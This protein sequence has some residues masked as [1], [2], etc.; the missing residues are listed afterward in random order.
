MTLDPASQFPR[1][2]VAARRADH[3]LSAVRALADGVAAGSIRNTDLKEAKLILGRAVENAWQASVC[4]PYFYAGRYETQPDDAQK[5]YY[6]ITISGLHDLLIA[7]RKL[8]RSTSTNEAVDAMRSIVAEAL[9][10]A[11]AADFLKSKIVKG[12]VSNNTP[13]KPQNPNKD[14]K[15]CPVCYR[16]I[17]V[18]NGK[19]AHHGYTRPGYGFQT[20][21]CGGI[22]FPPL[23]ISPEGL[24]WALQEAQAEL[25][26]V[27][28]LYDDRSALTSL[29][30]PTSSFNQPR[31]AI[32]IDDPRW[33]RMFR[34]Y[35]AQL[36]ATMRHL[37]HEIDERETR[38]L[39]WK[40]R[41]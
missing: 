27:E 18:Q 28:S 7:N 35:C 21:S 25:K 32:T 36:E 34:A 41:E 19:M 33:P 1:L 2:L 26:K 17:A 16:H 20:A 13:A 8:S 9:P 4:E 23:E 22:K 11:E 12:R 37:R 31:H 39:N 14:V 5:L 6:S 30:K 29:I 24:Q 38:L 40:E 15:T 3:F 10:L